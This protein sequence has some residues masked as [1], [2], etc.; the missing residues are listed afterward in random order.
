MDLVELR[1]ASDQRGH[2]RGAD[3]AADVPGEVDEPGHGVV[4]LGA[5]ADVRGGRGGDED[6]G[7]GKYWRTRSHV[8]DGELTARSSCC[9]ERYMVHARR[10]QPTATRWRV[11]TTEIS[12]PTIGISRAGGARRTTAPSRPSARCTPSGSG[13][14]RT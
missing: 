11:C 14:R 8:T 2:D 5:D 6:Q 10:S 4:L 9:V 13:G 12:R 7:I 3:T 1:L